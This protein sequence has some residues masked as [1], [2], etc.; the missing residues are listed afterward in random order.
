MRPADDLILP[1]LPLLPRRAWVQ[2]DHGRPPQAPGGT[3]GR[4]AWEEHARAC[5]GLG[6]DAARVAAAGGLGYE[7]AVK[8]LGW[9]PRTWERA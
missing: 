9:E 6:K 2:A 4:I 5:A 1:A 7:E 3:L 8:G